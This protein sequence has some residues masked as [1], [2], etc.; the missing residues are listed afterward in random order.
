MDS[1]SCEEMPGDSPRRLR[2]SGKILGSLGQSPDFFTASRLRHSVPEFRHNNW[3]DGTSAASKTPRLLLV[4]P[5]PV[6]PASAGGKIRVFEM[7]RL[8]ARRGFS[9]ATFRTIGER[10]RHRQQVTSVLIIPSWR[11]AAVAVPSKAG[12]A[13]S[14]RSVTPVSHRSIMAN[15]GRRGSHI[16][17]RGCMLLDANTV[18][19][20][21]LPAR[22]TCS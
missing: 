15:I 6:F 7:A 13:T 5:Y 18:K 8:L 21:V 4:A 14:G 10:G 1:G 2:S 3:N 9:A 20:A 19:N 11:I 22:E 17:A 12:A 16:D